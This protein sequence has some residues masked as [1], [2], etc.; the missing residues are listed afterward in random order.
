MEEALKENKL[1]VFGEINVSSRD[2]E[3]KSVAMWNTQSTSS[4]FDETTETMK[5]S[6]IVYGESLPQTRVFTEAKPLDDGKYQVTGVIGIYDKNRKLLDDLNLTGE[7]TVKTD[8]TGNKTV[9]Q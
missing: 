1:V 3:G 5:K 2:S 6:Y 9:L 7:F 4:G 8:E